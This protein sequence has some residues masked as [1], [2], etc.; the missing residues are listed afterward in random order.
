MGAAPA[1]ARIGPVLH[2]LPRD[3][4]R[5]A[6]FGCASVVVSPRVFCAWHWRGFLLHEQRE[7]CDAYGTALW[8][9]AL[10]LARRLALK[11]DPRFRASWAEKFGRKN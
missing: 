10:I 1:R 2:G 3:P 6:A 11:R 4:H 8:P 5:C 9:S 7:L